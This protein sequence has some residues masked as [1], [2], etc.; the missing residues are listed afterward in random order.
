MWELHNKVF[1]SWF[2]WYVFVLIATRTNFGQIHVY[3]TPPTCNASECNFLYNG[4]LC[5]QQWWKRRP[6]GVDV[7]SF[8]SGVWS[9]EC[10][11][12]K[13]NSLGLRSDAVSGVHNAQ[14]GTFAILRHPHEGCTCCEWII[15]CANK[16]FNAH[17]FASC[18]TIFPLVGINF[19]F[20]WWKIQ[21][22]LLIHILR[23]CHSHDE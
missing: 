18:Y 17:T 4:R 19:S 6:G 2:G 12:G 5:F 9:L 20:K 15:P 3:I 23:T 22:R 8:E 21:M 1:K 7:S 13:S 14:P 10:R 11:P 16:V